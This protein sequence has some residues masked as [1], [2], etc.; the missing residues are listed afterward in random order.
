MTTETLLA[1]DNLTSRAVE[2]AAEALHHF[3]CNM[4]EA[5]FENSRSLFLYALM[6][7]CDRQGYVFNAELDEAR[8][9]YA[10]TRQ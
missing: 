8:A 10:D 4:P 2:Q 9:R 5:D 3:Q 1:L 7:L 6:H